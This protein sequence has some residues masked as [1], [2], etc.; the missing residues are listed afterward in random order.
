MTEKND[1]ENMDFIKEFIKNFIKE[2]AIQLSERQE[3]I[4]RYCFKKCVR[5]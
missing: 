1:V 4:L 2:K 5:E 3:K